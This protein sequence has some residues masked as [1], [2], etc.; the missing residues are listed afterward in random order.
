M[1][2]VEGIVGLMSALREVALAGEDGVVIKSGPVSP[3]AWVRL[4]TVGLV[5]A[6]A[7]PPSEQEDGLDCFSR[8][9]CAGIGAASSSSED[10]VGFLGLPKV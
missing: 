2:G 4:A 7:V 5:L 8:M 3:R 9:A 1:T 10:G 6:T